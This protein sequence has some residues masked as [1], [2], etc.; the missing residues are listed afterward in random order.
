MQAQEQKVAQTREVAHSPV[1]DASLL[2]QVDFKWLMA[3][4]GWWI[5]PTRFHRDPS[6]AIG[7]LRLAMAS[8]SGTLRECAAS[9]Q[10]Q[11]DRCYCML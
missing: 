8:P 4:Q 6:Y 5:D 10:A 3:G 11:I 9:L 2:A 1:E 7:L